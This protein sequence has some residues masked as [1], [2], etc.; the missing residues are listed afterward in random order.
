MLDRRQLLRRGIGVAA[1]VAAGDL[2]AACAPSDAG[3][4][5]TPAPSPTPLASPETTSLRLAC[6]ACDAPI[7]AAER[8]LRDEGF[9]DVQI[10]GMPNGRAS[11]DAVLGGKADLGP[12]FAFEFAGA[13]QGRQPLI[14]LAGI[15]PGCIE[16]WAIPSI[17][18]IKDLR[19]RTMVVRSKTGSDVG[20]LLAVMAV[21]NAGIDPKDV[22]F[23]VQP[24]ADLMKLY[25]EGKND[26]V[27]AST[28]SAVT[29][30]ANPA[31]KGHVILDAAMDEPWSRQDCCVIATTADWLRA[32]PI[33]A[34]R[35]VRAILRAADQ[36]PVD[37]AEA[38]KLVT[39]KGLFG[40]PSNFALVRGAANM[41]PLKWR[42]L[43]AERSVRFYVRLMN[44]GGI[45]AA[46]PD[47][48]VAKTLDL[49]ILRELREEMKG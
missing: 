36:L 22:N 1:L 12:A 35:A 44:A 14:G 33:A 9:T 3:K 45:V 13:V 32:N 27:A 24:D 10:L 2:I 20:Y 15:H 8:Y 46:T 29:L 47:E 25:L 38:A 4:P 26:V 18:S 23:V 42:E 34:K 5:A 19:G 7:M 43:D 31:N 48:V 41:V 37:R 21:E 30:R 6:V 17:S 49:R 28:T 16:L 40:G 11:V 39:D